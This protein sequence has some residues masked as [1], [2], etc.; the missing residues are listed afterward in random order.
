MA[1]CVLHDLVPCFFNPP[2]FFTIATF[3]LKAGIDRDA[4]IDKGLCVPE[5][6]KSEKS[7]YDS[8]TLP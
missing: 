5:F 7:A 3:E 2:Q 4:E 6:P 1:R 8:F